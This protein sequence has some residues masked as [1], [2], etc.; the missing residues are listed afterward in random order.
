MFTAVLRLTSRAW[1]LA[2]VVSCAMLMS[3]AALPQV[4]RKESHAITA[5][6]Q[7]KLGRA[8]APQLALHPGESGFYPLLQG[9]DAFE[10]RIALARD[11]QKSLDLQYYVY[12]EDTTGMVLMGELV[13]AAERGVRVRL[14]LDD[15]H[16]EGRD[17]VLT[18][19]AS[20][21]DIEVRL[22]NPFANRNARWIDFFG[23]FSRINRRMH[24]KAMIADN[25]VAIVGGRNIGDEY[26][27]AKSDVDF[28][29]FDLFAIGPIVKDVSTSFDTYWNSS[30]SYPVGAFSDSKPDKQAFAALHAQIE[31]E[32]EDLRKTPYVRALEQSDLSQKLGRG[33][34]PS[35]W[36]HA[37]VIVDPPEKMS[38]PPEKNHRLAI[39]K[40]AHVLD[41]TKKELILVSPYFIPGPE[42]VLWL[43]D[44]IKRGVHV[45]VITNSFEATDVSAVHAGYTN[46]RKELLEAGVDL[47]EMKAAVYRDKSLQGRQRGL[48]GS[49]RAS[50]HAKAYMMDRRVLFVGSLNLDGRSAMLN[51]EMGVVL[52]SEAL[53]KA[54]Y[55]SAWKEL[56]D[57]SYHVQ[58][59]R[60]DGREVMTWT[61]H[62]NGKEVRLEGE[63]GMGPL[64]HIMQGV[65]RLLPFED[66]F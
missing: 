44:M 37:R 62:E 42:G 55:D 59:V 58:L 51:T 57:V 27:S 19:L 28:S 41:Q 17:E 8:L 48:T 10:A 46:Y 30:L 56:L 21:P 11:A 1:W 29:D 3:C 65:L 49:S 20:H 14:L 6:T 36:G 61:T 31:N 16:T 54:L 66:Q 18:I 9:I 43:R 53:C 52:E 34:P 35:Y 38:L 47:Y 15:V 4:E 5:T 13:A 45:T 22:F 50:L 7:T 2:V 24:N 63:P 32:V 33:P 60:D 12:H 39:S 25:Q 23:D 26:F 64:T 40:L